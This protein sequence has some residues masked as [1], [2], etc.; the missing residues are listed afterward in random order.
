MSKFYTH[1]WK[2]RAIK[3]LKLIEAAH[4]KLDPIEIYKE[5][6]NTNNIFK[7]EIAPKDWMTKAGYRVKVWSQDEKKAKDTEAL[8]QGIAALQLMP[9][10]PKLLEVIQ[11]KG[12]ELADLTP[13]EI[14]AIMDFEEQKMMMMGNG[15][16]GAP[17]QPGTQPNEAP[18]PTPP[19]QPLP[20]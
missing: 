6:K 19:M 18:Q 1:V 15:M 3:Y 12:L 5:G 16:M 13:D 11:R 9:G 17:P 8:N 10:N 20:V 4:D 7:R 14:T 2:Q